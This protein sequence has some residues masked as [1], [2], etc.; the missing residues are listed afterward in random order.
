MK[1]RS[2]PL[3]L[4]FL[5]LLAACSP[6]IEGPGPAVG[7]P[8]LLHAVAVTGDGTHLPLKVWK[9]ADRAPQSVLLALHGFNDYSNFVNGMAAWLAER[10]V[11]VYAYDQRGFGATETAGLWSG[12]E[13]LVDDLHTVAALV[14]GHHPGVPLYL[15]GDSMGGAVA[16]VAL[17]GKDPPDVDGAVLVAPAVWGRATMPWYQRLALETLGHTLPWFP[18]SGTGLGILASDNRVMLHNQWLD[19]LVIKETR[20]DAIYGLVGLMDAALA[21]ATRLE[22]RCLILYG[23]K[24]QIIPEKPTRR[25]LTSLPD[26]PE[27]RRTVALYENGYHMLLRDVAAETYWADVLHWLRDSGA[28]LP[29][30]ADRRYAERW[31]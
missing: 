13:A 4:S 18:V 26:V 15:L 22:S 10:G 30:G 7:A 23:E 28:P 24:D 11:A 9:P 1:W 5:F 31:Q 29:S 17:T 12:T 16:L 25:M 27:G 14:R 6:R 8:H 21:A 20:I 19:P 2:A 3:L